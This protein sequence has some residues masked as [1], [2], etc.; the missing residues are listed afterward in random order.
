MKTVIKMLAI[1]WLMLSYIVFMATFITAYSVP[2]KAAYVT[3]NNY[4]EADFEMFMIIILSLFTI[5]GGVYFFR[6]TFE[7]MR[8]E[9]LSRS[10]PTH[11][12]AKA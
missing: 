10:N 12:H 6:E 1:L 8:K 9:G 2:Q 11:I 5:V 7:T 4:G 3:I